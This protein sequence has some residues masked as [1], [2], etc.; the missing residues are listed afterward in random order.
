MDVE[1]PAEEAIVE[2]ADGRR[3]KAMTI[4]AVTKALKQEF[5]DIS[6][7]KIRYLEDQKLLSPRRTPGG[8]RLYS[9]SDVA[10]L[11]TI[12]RLQRD[13][14]LPLRVIR[15]ELASGRADEAEVVPA[16]RGRTS[17]ARRAAVSVTA[18]RNA[19]YSLED[20]VEETRADPALI[21]E[22]EEYGVIKGQTRAGDEVLRRDRAGDRQGRHRARAVRRRRAQ[23]ARLPDVG[24]PRGPAAAD[25]PRPGAALAQSRAAQGGDRGAGEPG[26]GR[27]APQAPAADPGPAPSRGLVDLRSY[28]RDIPDFPKPGVVFRDITP[29]MADA[30]GAGL[31]GHARWPTWPG[32][33]SPEVVIG[34]EARGFLLGPALAR[35]LG[36]GFVLARK[37]GKLPHETERAEYE[38]E[39]GTDALELHSDAVAAGARVLVHDDLLATG[40]TARAL[41]E[42]VEKVGGEVVGCGFLIELAFLDGRS[43]LGRLRRRRAARR[44]G[45]VSRADR[46]PRPRLRRT[47]GAR[48]ARRRRPAPPAALVAEG[49]ARRGGRRRSLHAGDADGEGQGRA[50]RLPRRRGG[51][52]AAAAL[53]AGHRGHAVRGVPRGGGDDDRGAAR[54]RRD[55][56]DDLDAAQAA[57]GIARI[58]GGTLLKRATRK[59]LDEA[60]DALEGLV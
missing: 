33:S 12:L 43:R 35:E 51:A 49:A 32:R 41:C 55:E 29:L 9:Q 11:R 39:Y 1:L 20:V 30:G 31:R 54:R 40:G 45:R 13:E 26:R 46:A 7:S 37:P 57:S 23:P 22:L 52:A 8:Y 17:G 2:T 59:Q 48:L 10:R 19:L 3:E 58:G 34:A 21:R 15:Q 36:A 24:R 5:S 16:P 56:G 28:I 47:A 25:D 14:F 4:G 27:D 38:L 42:L 18:E 44:R 6:I 50:G 53:R 60:L